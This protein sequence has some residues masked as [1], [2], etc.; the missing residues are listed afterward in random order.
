MVVPEMP[1]NIAA[2]RPNIAD[3]I[4]SA[5][6]RISEWVISGHSVGGA[7]AAQYTST[8]S[9]VIDGL[10]IW[11]SYPPDKAD[12]SSLRIPVVLIYGSRETR[13]TIS[14]VADRQ[15][16]LPE[17]TI[18]VRI[19]GGDHHQ[20]GAYEIDPENHLATI[21]RDV[22]HTQIIDPTLDL[23]ATISEND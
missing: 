8:H 17:D 16:L 10:V 15:H 20:F 21:S 7:M 13:V 4:I 6:P 23:L 3:K 9:D 11:A 12:L 22:Q 18:Y 19:E 2:F 14:S 5:Y 1:L